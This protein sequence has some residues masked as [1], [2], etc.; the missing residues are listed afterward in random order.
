MNRERIDREALKKLIATQKSFES[1]RTTAAP[2]LSMSSSKTA[3]LKDLAGIIENDS[4]LSARILKITNSGFYSLRQKV[5]TVSH[6]ISLLGWN[7]VKMISLGSSLLTR[8][9]ATDHR[10]FNHSVRTAQ[11]AR[12]LATEAHFYKVEEIAVVGLLHDFGRVIFELFFPEKAARL[13]QYA[14]DHGVPIHVA[15]RELYDADHGEVGGWT[16]EEW[17]LPENIT[18]SVVRHHAFDRNTYHARKT[19]V[20]QVADVFAFATDYR[21]PG[22]EKVPE[23]SPE[24]LEVLGFREQDARELLNTVMNMRFEPIIM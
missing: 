20:I 9:C 16:L 3:S 11:I 12:F 2:I 13:R 18:D 22:W 1:V 4:E 5:E 17:D 7:A 21:G 10:L 6:A 8:M 14:V 24:A 19:A 15:E 23:M